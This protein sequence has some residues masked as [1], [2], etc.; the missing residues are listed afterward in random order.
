MTDP[1]LHLIVGPNGSGK[2][3][4]HDMVIGPATRLEVVNADVPAARYWPD[5]TVDHAYE[6]ARLATQRRAELI[7]QPASF[8]TETVFSHESKAQLIRDARHTGYLVTLHVVAI[9]EALAVARVRIRALNGGHDAPEDKIRSRFHRLW[10]L[11]SAAVSI[12]DQATVYDN[13]SAR[14]PFRIIA[15]FHHG[16]AVA[17]TEWPP[18]APPA[19]VELTQSERPRG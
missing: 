12:V 10:P 16:R 5:D 4:L 8:V 18:W 19:L 13:T 9:P 3:T 1:V 15:T 7:A 11:V 14:D 17:G 6:V 2:S